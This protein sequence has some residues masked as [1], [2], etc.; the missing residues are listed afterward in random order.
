[1]QIS[2]HNP[3]KVKKWQIVVGKIEL[4]LKYIAPCENGI[5]YDVLVKII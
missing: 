1:V 4:L 3:F 5:K 2:C